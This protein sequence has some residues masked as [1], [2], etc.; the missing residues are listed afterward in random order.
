[1]PLAVQFNDTTTGLPTSWNWSFGDGSLSTAQ[2]PV[3]V[4]TTAGNYSVSL[5]VTNAGGSNLTI[6]TKYITAT[7]PAP[8]ANF[9]ANK[10]TGSAPLAVRF[11]DT[12][13]GSPT[14]WNWS[15][16]EGNYSALQHPVF[17]Y[18]IPGRFTVNL[19]STNQYGSDIST[20]TGYITVSSDCPIANFTSDVTTGGYN[21]TVQFIDTSTGFPAEWNWSFGDGSFSSSRDPMHTYSQ[22]DDIP[23]R[24]IVSLNAT[25]VF[26]SNTTEKGNYINVMSFSEYYRSISSPAGN[27][28]TSTFVGIIEDWRLQRS[29]PTFTVSPSTSV[30]VGLIEDWRLQRPLL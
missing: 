14:G 26:G 6:R 21:L 24:Y 28:S 29:V 22:N 8:V 10:T 11:T 17:V 20:K 3:Y 7:P 2:H 1:V 4:Y 27:I 25:N 16:G 23:H 19:T 5:N 12:T 15:F 9:T 30:F 13:T 18:S